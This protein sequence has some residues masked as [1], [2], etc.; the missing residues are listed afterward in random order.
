MRS[1]GD[2]FGIV[3]GVIHK[4][5]PL[6]DLLETVLKPIK[7][8]TDFIQE[9]FNTPGKVA[10]EVVKRLM[11]QVEIIRNFFTAWKNMG[12]AG[13]DM[14]NNLIQAVAANDDTPNDITVEEQIEFQHSVTH[15]W[16]SVTLLWKQVPLV[17]TAS[18]TLTA[19]VEESK[20]A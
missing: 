9:L 8:F 7:P 15:F 3:A 13:E 17:K 2:L 6:I 12:S 19:V 10:A 11:P 5:N 4:L 20:R 1:I 16:N 14:C 18:G